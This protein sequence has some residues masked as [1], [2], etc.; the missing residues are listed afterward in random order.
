MFA[1]DPLPL[2]KIILQTSLHNEQCADHPSRF[3]QQTIE[4]A[5]TTYAQ[6]RDNFVLVTI[7][8]AANGLST[9]VMAYTVVS[10]LTN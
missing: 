6:L 2:G 1:Y 9:E 4:I 3:L 8:E 5:G 10:T 7:L